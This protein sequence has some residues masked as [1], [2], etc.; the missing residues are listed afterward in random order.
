VAAKIAEETVKMLRIYPA[1]SR[2]NS[3][4]L[5][6]VIRAC[7]IAGHDVHDWRADD[8]DWGDISDHNYVSALFD[9]NAVRQFE[10]NR[11]A[12]RRCDVCILVLPAGRCAHS[13]FGYAVGLDKRAVVFLDAEHRGPPDL[14]HHFADGFADSV[15]SLLDVLEQIEDQDDPQRA[16]FRGTA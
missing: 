11:E 10:A 6:Q 12:I 2:K 9:S 1:G 13:E 14:M 7:R 8:F 16:R 3:I 5:D 4:M 15:E